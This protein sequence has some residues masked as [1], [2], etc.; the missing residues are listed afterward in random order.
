MIREIDT[1]LTGY[2]SVTTHQIHKHKIHIYNIPDLI[3]HRLLPAPF[4]LPA[5]SKKMIK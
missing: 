5:I 4:S 2:I 1:P 3:K